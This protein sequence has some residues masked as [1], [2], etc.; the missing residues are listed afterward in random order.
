MDTEREL[1]LL[2]D[3]RRVAE[4]M[5]S[6]VRLEQRGDEWHVYWQHGYVFT[7]D[8]FRGV[9]TFDALEKAFA[10]IVDS[11]RKVAHSEHDLAEYHER[12]ANAIDAALRSVGRR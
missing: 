1:E 9:T 10:F 2:R 6:S 11:A 7:R 4:A 8:P 5:R 3:C 12:A